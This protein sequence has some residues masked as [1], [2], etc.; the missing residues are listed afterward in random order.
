MLKEKLQKVFWGWW[1]VAACALTTLY[2]AGTFHYGFTVFV[3]PIVSE[4]GWSMALV[5]GA[6]SLYRLESGVAAPL[7]GF[8]VDRIGPRRV[9]ILGASLMGAGYICLSQVRTILPFYISF[10]VISLGFGFSTG[11]IVA[12]SLI[13]KWFIRKRGKALGLYF[14]L[15]GL[16]GLLIPVLSHLVVL[17]GWRTTVFILGPCTWLVVFPVTIILRRKPEE[18]GL[19]PDGESSTEARDTSDHSPSAGIKEVNF[20]LR[21]AMHAPSYWLLA[22]CFSLYQTTNSAIFVHLVPY[23]ISVGFDARVAALV[24]T[25][26]T[27]ASVFGRGGFGWLSDLFRKKVLLMICFLTQSIGILILMQVQR[28]VSSLYVFSFILAFGLTYGGNSVLRPATVA[29]LYG[30]EKFG[31]IWGV[32]QGISIFGGIA[33]PVVVGLIYDAYKSYRLGLI[34]LSL[35]NLLAFFLVMFLRPPGSKDKT[36]NGSEEKGCATQFRI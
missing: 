14:G 20:S 11:Q 25:A 1:I 19:L 12:T 5:S 17:Y 2:G 30:R 10:L 22:V 6:F 9:V 32:L 26:V 3:N 28:N 27:A 36:G 16:S 23:L 31:T 34:F 29:E 7:A 15:M 33:G 21:T 35:V 8:L 24:V 4:L 13:S 18:W